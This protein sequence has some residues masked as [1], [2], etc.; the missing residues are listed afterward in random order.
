MPSSNSPALLNTL[1]QNS[2][3]ELLALISDTRNEAALK[4]KVELI[5]YSMTRFLGEHGHLND[6]S[7]LASTLPCDIGLDDPD[8]ILRVL[9]NSSG[10]NDEA[11]MGQLNEYVFD[12]A[13]GCNDVPGGVSGYFEAISENLTYHGTTFDLF[14]LHDPTTTYTVQSRFFLGYGLVFD[15]AEYRVDGFLYDLVDDQVS[16][17]QM[18][19]SNALELNAVFL[20]LWEEGLERH[21]DPCHYIYNYSGGGSGGGGSSSGGGSGNNNDDDGANKNYINGPLSFPPYGYEGH[22]CQGKTGLRVTEFHLARRNEGGWFGGKSEVY[23]NVSFYNSGNPL[24]YLQTNDRSQEIDAM[25]IAGNKYNLDRGK[26][27]AEVPD[28]NISATLNTVITTSSGFTADGDWV[29]IDSGLCEGATPTTYNRVY[30]SAFERDPK[31]FWKEYYGFPYH[32]SIIEVEG[33]VDDWQPLYMPHNSDCWVDTTL[34]VSDFATQDHLY[35]V[36]V[37]AGPTTISYTQPAANTSWFHIEL[38]TP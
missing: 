30:V 13:K 6:N 4:R 23:L 32:D 29:L 21:N 24:L 14:T 31:P 18:T 20:E 9:G 38:F 35:L 11:V 36:D 1:P 12:C 7:D 37:G 22:M 28:N 19:I 16:S 5:A 8:G 33:S 10:M 2:E 17:V 25:T 34:Q 26:L 15:G 27:L 3:P